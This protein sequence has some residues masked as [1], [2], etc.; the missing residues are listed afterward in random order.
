MKKQV[1]IKKE[2]LTLSKVKRD[3]RKA[4]AVRAIKAYWLADAKQAHKELLANLDGWAE[5]NNRPEWE[6]SEEVERLG[7]DYSK[8]AWLDDYRCAIYEALYRLRNAVN[9]YRM[10]IPK[11]GLDRYNGGRVLPP[12]YVCLEEGLYDDLL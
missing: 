11:G 1:T 3:R 4:K 5:I 9:R 8:E 2:A 6:F 10:A 7:E 12:V